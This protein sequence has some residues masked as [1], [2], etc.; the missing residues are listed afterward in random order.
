[1]WFAGSGEKCLYR[2]DGNRLTSFRHDDANP[3]S[4]GLTGIETVYADNAG[5]I[6]IGGEGLDQYDPATGIFKH[7]KHDQNDPASMNGN[8]VNSILKDHRG[9]L[10]V[11]TG[12]G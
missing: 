8:H 5:M 3:N 9:M 10:W 4:L 11:G 12:N 2:Y 6:W 1:M 7:Y